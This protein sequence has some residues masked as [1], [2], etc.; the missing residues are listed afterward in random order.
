MGRLSDADELMAAWRALSGGQG[1]SGWRTIAV[2]SGT[3]PRLVAGRRL[4]GNEEAILARLD[5]P[6]TVPAGQLPSAAGFSVEPAEL[7]DD[8][9]HWLALV[10]QPGAGLDLFTLM[11]VDVVGLVEEQHGGGPSD[12]HSLLARISAWQRFMSRVPTGVLSREAEL[13]LHGEL[14]ILERLMD[15]GVHAPGALQA[16]MGPQHGLHDFTFG[17][18]ALEV[19]TSLSAKGLEARISSLDQLDVALVTPLHLVCVGMRPDLSGK[20]LGERVA[21]LRCRIAAFE[22]CRPLLEIRLLQA[23]WLDA[24]A[25]HYTRRLEVDQLKVFEVDFDFPT[26]T[27]ASVPSGI[28]DAHYTVD[29][30]QVTS[31]SISL[32]AA[33]AAQQVI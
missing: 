32:N 29:I 6:L 22:A 12:A 7:G 33:L 3:T 14:I 1:A 13:G 21:A 31:T 26:L 9:T 15:L 27:R 25:S 2:A 24:R 16:W 11:C 4:P 28:V 19:K 8:R 30:A 17:S 5:G 10:R 18:G 23:G 20:T